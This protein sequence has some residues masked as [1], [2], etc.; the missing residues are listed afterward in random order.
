MKYE[1][2]GLISHET[3]YKM[4]YGNYKGLGDCQK[5]LRQG[6]G[7][8][9]KRGG[10]PGRVGIELRP[11]IADEKREIGHWESDTM[12]GG[13]HAGVIVTH[14]DK[15]SKF[16]VAGLGKDKTSAQINK[17]TIELSRFMPKD[18]DIRQ[19]ERVQWA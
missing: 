10:I 3:I 5:Y 11:A 2:K 16:L 4:I 18:D 6:R 8:R 12:I 17:I 9:R 14:V 7:R 19:R 13:N 1:G 15:A